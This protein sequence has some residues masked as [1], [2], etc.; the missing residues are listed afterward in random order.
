MK[1][2]HQTANLSSH[3]RLPS[4]SASNK[5][6]KTNK[7]KKKKKKKGGKNQSRRELPKAKDKHFLHMATTHLTRKK[8]ENCVV[9]VSLCCAFVFVLFVLFL[10][11]V[12]FCLSV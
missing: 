10:F 1:L 2:D 8:Y 12:L 5:T 7:N 9:F 11:F 3:W 6:N 4:L